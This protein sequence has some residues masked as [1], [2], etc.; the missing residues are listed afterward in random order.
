MCHTGNSLFFYYF[1]CII[2]IQFP[3][4]T[5]HTSNLWLPV[6]ICPPVYVK[7]VL[8]VMSKSVAHFYLLLWHSF[9]GNVL[10][11]HH[12]VQTFCLATSVSSN[13]WRSTLEEITSDIMM[14][15]ENQ[16]VPLGANTKPWFL[17]G[18]DKQNLSTLSLFY[19][20]SKFCT[21]ILFVIV[22]L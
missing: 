22:D 16:G 9:D 17:P 5:Q 4:V 18:W 8:Q 10:P 13:H 3:F 6:A 7:G 11:I 14:K 20:P 2:S 12:T 19:V 15:C 1:W 21:V